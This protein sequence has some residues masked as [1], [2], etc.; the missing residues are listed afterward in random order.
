MTTYSPVKQNPYTK[1]YLLVPALLLVVATTIYP[2]LSAFAL[3]FQQWR[4]NRTPAPSGFVGLDNYLNAFSD[5]Y[6]LLSVFVTLEYTLISVALSLVVGL[7]MALVLQKRTRLN[8]FVRLFL[9]FPFAV[10]PALKGL[11][12][13]FFL[14]Q[15]YGIF[16]ALISLIFPPAKDMI[17]LADSFWGLFWLAVSELW[18]WAPL[19]ALIFIGALGSISTE[20]FEAA[21][22]DGAEN[23]DIFW[24]ITLPLL[25]P[26][27]LIAALLKTIFSL[28]LFD[29]VVTMTGGGPGRSTQTL[30]FYVYLTAFR[31]LDMGYAAA[32]A[33]ILFA[34]LSVFA[35]Y[36][37]RTLN[38][39]TGA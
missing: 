24:K 22:V 9:I 2:L 13:V 31:N 1:F 17:W 11:S 12:F 28:K 29:Q 25:K 8:L 18:G 14:N 6:F 36:Y 32:L 30:N 26:V 5:Q 19:Y 33:F 21:K 4:L 27:L 3:S 34:V 35:Y 37:M 20:I 39:P 38:R 10:S 7:T 23:W 16:H 15:D